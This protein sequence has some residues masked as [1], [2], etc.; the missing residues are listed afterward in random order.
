[1]EKNKKITA[2]VNFRGR[3]NFEKEYLEGEDVSHLPYAED[4]IG[5]GLAK[6]D[7]KADEK[8]KVKTKA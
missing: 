2:L 5:R 3:D 1:M 8:V 6:T 4:L 7:E